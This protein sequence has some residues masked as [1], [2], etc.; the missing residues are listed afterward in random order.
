MANQ[1]KFIRTP[2]AL[3]KLTFTG[4]HLVKVS[5]HPH[6]RTNHTYDFW[7]VM[8]TDVSGPMGTVGR[9][10]ERY[11]LTF[12]YV[13]FRYTLFFMISSRTQVEECIDKAVRYGH[14]RTGQFPRIIYADNASEYIRTAVKFVMTAVGGKLR[15]TIPYN[16]D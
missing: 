15:T 9:A 6:K 2:P 8:C 11:M 16:P 7:E 12:T 3:F 4:C 10:G 5:R 14:S 1:L 13:G